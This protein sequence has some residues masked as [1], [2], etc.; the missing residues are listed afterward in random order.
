MKDWEP[1][2]YDTEDDVPGSAISTCCGAAPLYWAPSLCT[3]CKE[4]CD[5][6]DEEEEDE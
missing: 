1:T 3:A 2:V 5:W 4:H 6:Y